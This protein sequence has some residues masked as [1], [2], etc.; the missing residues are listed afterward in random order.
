GMVTLHPC[1]FTHGPHP[2]ALSKMLQQT[3]PATDEYAVMVDARDQLK[4][5]EA[6]PAV[7]LADYHKSWQE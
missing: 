7:E 1:G 4:I 3:Q 5:D 6:A 2:Q